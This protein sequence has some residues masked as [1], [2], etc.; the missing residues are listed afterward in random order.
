MHQREPCAIK[1]CLVC[2]KSS[3]VTTYA[4]CYSEALG[5][6]RLRAS[7]SCSGGLGAAG[8]GFAGAQYFEMPLFFHAGAALRVLLPKHSGLDE[9]SPS[10]H[11]V[12]Q[13]YSCLI[14]RECIRCCCAS[15]HGEERGHAECVCCAAAPDGRPNRGLVLTIS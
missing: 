1:G 9:L 5:A 8:N 13:S 14:G 2:S 7:C 6:E 3:V 12:A 4:P 11:V 10:A 15:W